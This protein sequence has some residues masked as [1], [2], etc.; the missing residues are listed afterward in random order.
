MAKISPIDP[1]AMDIRTV[2]GREGIVGERPATET[3]STRSGPGNVGEH[4]II[5]STRRDSRTRPQG[6]NRDTVLGAFL[7]AKFLNRPPGRYTMSD[8]LTL[9]GFK[10]S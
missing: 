9:I 5:F 1:E 4:T 8:Y 3:A 2:H 10:L 6:Y 7:A